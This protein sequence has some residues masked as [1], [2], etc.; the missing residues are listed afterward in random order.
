M[1]VIHPFFFQK[2]CR[3]ILIIRL[4]VRFLAL[5]W[6]FYPGEFY[7]IV[8][9]VWVFPCFKVLFCPVLFQGGGRPA[10]LTPSQGRP[11]NYVLM[12]YI[13]NNP[14]SVITGI[15]GSKRRTRYAWHARL[16]I[17]LQTLNQEV[18]CWILGFIVGFPLEEN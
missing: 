15:K 6:D 11:S 3:C 4:R 10:L 5:P 2:Q 18:S 8:S 17:T 16:A 1:F 7:S 14:D 12:W 13:E 9:N